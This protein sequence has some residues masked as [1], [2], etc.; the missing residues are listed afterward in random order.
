MPKDLK[1]ISIT[2]PL[3]KRNQKPPLWYAVYTKSRTEKKVLLELEY[4]GIEAYLPIYKKLRQWSDRKKWVETPLISGYLFV[5]INNIDYDKVFRTQGVVAYVRFEGKAATIPDNQ[6]DAIKQL[7]RQHQY[8]IK[9]SRE[10]F[11]K[12]DYIEVIGGPLLG[13]KG[14]L[15]SIRGKKRVAV[16]LAQ[17]NL[18][19][20][21]ELPLE[22]IRKIDHTDCP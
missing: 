5:H 12:G 21:V 10:I 22:E 11:T 8:K 14:T 17:L 15:I 20:I 3:Q 13:L 2:P 1:N 4:Q 9:I 18:S 16:Q 19:L 6:I 7:L